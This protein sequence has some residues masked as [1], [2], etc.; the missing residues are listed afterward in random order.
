MAQAPAQAIPA[1][2]EQAGRRPGTPG[3]LSRWVQHR[4]NART[5][6]K[7]RKGKG[8]MMGMDLLVLHTVGRRSGRPHATPLAWFP[9]PEAGVDGARL[10]VAS[11]GG[12]RNPDWFVNLTARAD[13]V[14]IEL[15]GGEVVAVTPQRLQ[16]DERDR[17][18]ER[19]AAAQPRIAKYQA[20]TERLYPVVRLVPR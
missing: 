14:S 16:G 18:W 2:G 19:I 10:V 11:G 17:A 15:A 6:R 12:A 4:M 13:Q 5:A 20:K 8:T 3:R 9:D 7:L 1:A